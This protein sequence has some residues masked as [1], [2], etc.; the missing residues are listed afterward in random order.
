[1]DP[2]PYF[3]TW[4][5]ERVARL[6]V[7]SH[8]VT[9]RIPSTAKGAIALLALHLVTFGPLLPTLGFYWDDWETILLLRQ[10]PP[11]QFWPYFEGTRPL[12]AWSFILFGPLLG[13]RPLAW[14]LFTLSLRWLASIMVLALIRRLWP[15]LKWQALAVAMLFAVYPVFRQQAIAVA[16]HQHWLA[17]LLFL[18]SAYA[19]LRAVSKRGR[20]HWIVVSVAAQLLHLGLLEYFVGLELLRPVL[21]HRYRQSLDEQGDTVTI[22][23][24]APA[25]GSNGLVAAAFVCWR[26]SYAL[27]HPGSGDQPIVLF[28]LLQAPLGALLT[29]GR[30]AFSDTIHVL[31]SNWYD[32]L[33][34]R[35]VEGVAPADIVGWLT[36][37]VGA[38]VCALG[39]NIFGKASSQSDGEWSGDRPG[40]LLP[41]GIV[42]FVLGMAPIWI[43]GRDAQGGLFSDRAALPAMLGASMLWV[44]AFAAMLRSR[45]HATWLICLAIGLA[46]GLHFRTANDYRWSWV[47]QQRFYWQLFWR[48]PDIRP[49]TAIVSDGDLFPYVRPTFSINVLYNQPDPPGD[50]AYRYYL[51]GR[52]APADLGQAQGELFVEDFRGLHFEADVSD[53]VV[54]YFDPPAANCLWVLESRDT[55]ERNLPELLQRNARYSDLSRILPSGPPG[56]I[57]PQEIFGSEPGGGWCYFYQKAALAE[58]VGDWSRVAQLADEVLEAGFWPSNTGPNSPHEWIPLIHGL[59]LDGRIEEA[60]RVSLASYEVN[61]EYRTLLCNLWQSLPRQVNREDDPIDMLSCQD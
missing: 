42:A 43:T 40:G 17:F 14:H 57:P 56:I 54:I 34:P 20:L 27:S 61:P 9:D 13:T 2:T 45:K 3:M 5:A 32:A 24:L 28:D 50:L 44:G 35:L 59:A 11:G 39:L 41:V 31:L 21:L 51:L 36:V 25:L 4:S 49:G 16:Y 23:Q 33:N 26:I 58:Q 10:F 37:L 53:T 52:E 29:L 55:D 47:K 38:G 30:L 1:M 46:C 12:A 48:A 22:R 18:T 7:W 15:K 6:V 8:A 60:V 19:M